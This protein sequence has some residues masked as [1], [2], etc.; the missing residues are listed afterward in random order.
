[1]T[2]NRR[3]VSRRNLLLGSAALGTAASMPGGLFRPYVSRA[4]DRPL[5]PH[6]LQSGDVSLNSGV[7][8][9]R[10][11][12]PAQAL[13][14]WST[15]ESFR[16]PTALPVLDALPESDYTV[17]LL[18][19]DLPAGQDIF[20]RVR[21]RD[22][23]ETSIVG[24]A[25]TGH[26]RTA[27]AGARDITFVWSGDT[28]GQGWGIDPDHGGM[29]T[30]ASM[31]RHQPDFFIHSGD[32]IYADGPIVAEKATPDG[33]V[34]RSLVLEE[35]TKVAETLG[36]FRAN[37]KYNLMDEHVR[38]LNAAV[39]MFAQWDDHEVTNNWYP[40][41]RL[42]AKDE[43][44]VKPVS[45]LA[46]RAA[47]AFHEYMPIATTLAEPQRIYRKIAY[48]PSLD[49]F[50]LDMR[51]YRGPNT[52]NDQ[53]EPGPE[54]VF[55]GHEQMT[56]LKRELTASKATWKV[57][58]ADMPLGVIVWNDGTNKRGS[59]AIANGV[60][61]KP[62]GRELEI[63]NLLSFIKHSGVTNTVWFTADVHYT[64][65]H[66]YDPNRAAFQDFLPFWEFVSGPLHSGTF[67]P[68][69]LDPTFG[70][71]VRYAKAPAEGQ[72]NLPPSAG[73]QFF[74]LVRIDGR[75][76]QMTVSLRDR[77]DAELWSVTLDP[78]RA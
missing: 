16:N 68:N 37:Y 25:Q 63:A 56:W 7:V 11:D 12:R 45:L 39:P 77:V 1:M 30:Y 15:E 23:A 4:A 34:W 60:E 59:E 29:L 3:G 62:L 65:A 53:A 54:T 61:G 19:E 35:K 75:T 55:L 64:A 36:E 72:T 20:Y 8:W 41:Y 27:P 74:G 24:E 73:L 14:E 51:T 26:F 21:F 2:V 22:L 40:G 17:K 69:D 44:T 58:A 32:T 10:T 48:G 28:A 71:E 5:I 6:G 9:A 78:V 67:G 49:V 43:Y 38:A 18:V 42:D 13:I 33:G 50:F 57:I 70:P 47:R 76:E 46:A 66:H 31:A 52:D